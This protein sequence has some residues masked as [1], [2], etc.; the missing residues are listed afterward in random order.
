MLDRTFENFGHLHTFISSLKFPF[1]NAAYYAAGN[2]CYHDNGV[3][4]SPIVMLDDS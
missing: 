3:P 4:W 2:F 1:Q